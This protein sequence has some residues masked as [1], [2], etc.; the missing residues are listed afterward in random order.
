MK[1]DKCPKCGSTYLGDRWV[2]G[3]KLQQYCY[4]SDSDERC[5]W[6]S[7]PR[8]PKRRPISNSKKLLVDE[9]PG[10]D[11]IVYDKF[12]HVMT[13]SHTY[14][15]EDAA[16]SEL[17]RELKRG[18]TDANA[19]PYTGVLFKTPSSVVIRGKM[20]KPKKKKKKKKKVVPAK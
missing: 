1:Y 20:F 14:S 6:K 18:E 5:N 3:R 4:I 10:W 19:G 8:T 9:S 17:K 13:L 11:Y 16:L 7:D 2:V 15:R 12:G